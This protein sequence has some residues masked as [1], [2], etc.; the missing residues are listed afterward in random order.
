MLAK[1]HPMIQIVFDPAANFLFNIG[2]VD[3]HASVIEFHPFQD[4]H[5][6]PVVSMQVPTLAI[7]V[8]QTMTVTEFDFL[9]DAI[10]SREPLVVEQ[11]TS[12]VDIETRRENDRADDFIKSL[13]DSLQEEYR[14]PP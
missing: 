10:H 12:I 6:F 14:L 7:I 1:N 8:Q 11:Q 3:E 13:L 5:G 4:K 2:E 9:G